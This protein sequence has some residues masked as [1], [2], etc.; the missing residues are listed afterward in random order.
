MSWRAKA[1][2]FPANRADSCYS[3]SESIADYS[4][5]MPTL[6]SSSLWG[7]ITNYPFNLMYIFNNVLFVKTCPFIINLKYLTEG[8]IF[9]GGKPSNRCCALCSGHVPP[10]PPLRRGGFSVWFNLFFCSSEKQTA[11]CGLTSVHKGHDW[12]E[13]LMILLLRLL[14]V[15]ELFYFNSSHRRHSCL[16]CQCCYEVFSG[17]IREW[18]IYLSARLLNPGIIDFNKAVSIMCLHHL[19]V[20]MSE[21]FTLFTF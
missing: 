21:K 11:L 17:F 4:A 19:N 20:F 9:K 14:L 7:Y 1:H 16:S 13:E 12:D 10:W 3:L 5:G 8:V 2:S 18:H 6:I 15:W